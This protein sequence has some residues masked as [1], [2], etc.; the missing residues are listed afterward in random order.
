MSDTPQPFAEQVNAIVEKAVE[1]KNGNMVLPD[2]VLKDIPEA[3]QHSAQTELRFRNTQRAFTKSQKENK[4]ITAVNAELVNHLTETVT[5]H[6]TPAQKAALDDLKV[7]D[8]EAW[9]AKLNEYEQ[10]AKTILQ[11]KLQEFD[12]KGEALSEAE[13]RAAKLA[14]FIETTGIELTDDIIANELPASFLKDLESNKITFDQF[15]TNAHKFLTKSVKIQGA[16]EGKVDDND[17]S[18]GKLPGGATP[19]KQAIEG[20]ITSRYSK[21]VF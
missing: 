11:T 6:V 10:E 8:P 7:R 1:D 15:L 18:I 16:G 12:K 4:K 5:L 21:L 9:R 20:D 17:I 2:E 19:T 3:L 13:V 14:S